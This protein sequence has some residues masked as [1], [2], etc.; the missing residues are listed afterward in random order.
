VIAYAVS[1]KYMFAGY[2]TIFVVLM[3]YLVSLFLRW[4]KLKRDLQFL[5]ELDSK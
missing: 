1:I 3:A 5:D 4:R 2:A